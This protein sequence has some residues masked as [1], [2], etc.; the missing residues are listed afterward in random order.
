MKRTAS[1]VAFNQPPAEFLSETNSMIRDAVANIGK[2]D[3]FLF[4]GVVTD[5]GTNAAAVQ[6]LGDHIEIVEYIGKTWG[7]PLEAGIAGVWHF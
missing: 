2:G 1:G 5:K 7:K 3:K 6:K 4:V